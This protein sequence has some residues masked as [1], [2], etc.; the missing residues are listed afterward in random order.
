MGVLANWN[1]H[2]NIKADNIHRALVSMLSNTPADSTTIGSVGES[3]RVIGT[4]ASMDKI[5]SGCAL[6]VNAIN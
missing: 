5:E 1:D 3:V 2:I 6:K 4:T